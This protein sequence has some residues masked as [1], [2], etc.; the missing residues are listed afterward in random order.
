[1][2]TAVVHLT[3]KEVGHFLFFVNADLLVT[4][5]QAVFQNKK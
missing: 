2:L 5:A 4:I 3:I 1:M